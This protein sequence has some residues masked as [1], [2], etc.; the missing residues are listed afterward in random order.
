VCE[1]K[2]SVHDSGN[3]HILYIYIVVS[4]CVRERAYV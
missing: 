3:A 2:Y 4:V 1:D